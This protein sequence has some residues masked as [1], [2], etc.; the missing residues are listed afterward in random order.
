MCF[1]Q[2]SPSEI[3]NGVKKLQN[4]ALLFHGAKLGFV[5]NDALT[6]QVNIQERGKRLVCLGRDQGTGRR[7]AR[8]RISLA[9]G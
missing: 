3:D 7:N 9:L 8:H 4:G 5:E 6:T 1:L 2:L